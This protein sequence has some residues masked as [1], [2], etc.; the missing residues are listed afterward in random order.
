MTK[1]RYGGLL[2]ALVLPLLAGCSLDARQR[3]QLSEKMTPGYAEGAISIRLIAEPQLNAWKEM[4]NSVTVFVVQGENNGQLEALLANKTELRALFNGASLSNSPLKNDRYTLMPGQQH[5]LHI[6]RVEKV[7]Q[8][9]VIAG[10]YPFPGEGQMARFSIPVAFNKAQWWRNEW[11]AELEPLQIAIT[12]GKNG[13]VNIT[14]AENIINS[15]PVP[16]EVN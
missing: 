4:P 1:S 14:G 3:Q 15:A 5:T 16:L 13:F 10:Y 11:Q 6:D 8:F 2:L 12:L 9:A 7:R